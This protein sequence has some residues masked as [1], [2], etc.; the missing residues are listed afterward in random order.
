[1]WTDKNHVETVSSK[2][3]HP[4]GKH[5][6]NLLTFDGLALCQVTHPNH[7]E[8]VSSKNIHPESRHCLD[9]LPFD[10]LAP[11]WVTIATQFR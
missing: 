2:N 3:I 9:L 10:V 7:V 1:M 4:E 6:L 5:C 8:A 11:C